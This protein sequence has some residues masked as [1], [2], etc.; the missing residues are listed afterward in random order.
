MLNTFHFTRSSSQQPNR[1]VVFL[2]F[3]AECPGTGVRCSDSPGGVSKWRSWNVDP[4]VWLCG[5]GPLEQLSLEW[6]L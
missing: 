1:A 2:F 5:V 3:K 6:L 4:A